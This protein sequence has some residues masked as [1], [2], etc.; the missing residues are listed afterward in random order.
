[1]NMAVASV[2]SRH[3]VKKIKEVSKKNCR[4]HM[5]NTTIEADLEGKEKKR[6]KQPI[7]REKKKKKEAV[8]SEKKREIVKSRRFQVRR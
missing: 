1:M 3:N 5:H 2:Q 4:F 6:K 7:I 8:K